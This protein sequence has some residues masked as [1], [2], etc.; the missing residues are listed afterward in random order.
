[1]FSVFKVMNTVAVG[2]LCVLSLQGMNTVAFG[3]LCVLSLQGRGT[4]G[5]V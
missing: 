4:Q 1:M 2:S 3:S 5:S